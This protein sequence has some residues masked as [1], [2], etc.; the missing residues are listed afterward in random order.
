MVVRAVLAEIAEEVI[1]AMGSRQTAIGG[2]HVTQTPFADER[3]GIAGLLERF[4]DRHVLLAKRLGPGIGRTGVASNP[5]VPV[6]L[7]GHQDASD[8]A[9]TVAPA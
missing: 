2:A 7:S 5:G 8:G 6:V 9:Q 1:E 3:G 4:R